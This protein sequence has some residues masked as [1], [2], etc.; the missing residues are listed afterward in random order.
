[1]SGGRSW[2]LDLRL[3]VSGGHD[4][5]P[6]GEQAGATLA[7]VLYPAGLVAQGEPAATGELDFEDHAVR[8]IPTVEDVSQTGA[9]A[10]EL[11]GGASEIEIRYGF[12]QRLHSTQESMA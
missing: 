1:V 10:V 3:A 11:E 8:D 6:A 2:R 5:V 9:V 7:V 12:R 4:E